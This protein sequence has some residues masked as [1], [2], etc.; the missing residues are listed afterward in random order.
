MNDN[1]N[2]GRRDRR[3]HG[4]KM[5]SLGLVVGIVL[6]VAA[7]VP[8]VHAW[9]DSE[10]KKLDRD[11][12]T[13]DG[14]LEIAKGQM[15]IVNG[16]AESFRKMAESEAAALTE[17]TNKLNAQTATLNE[18]HSRFTVLYD[19]SGSPA[20]GVPLFHGIVTLSL[21][22]L[23]AQVKPRWLIPAKVKPLVVGSSEWIA[24]GYIDPQ[25]RVLEGPFTPLPPQM[26]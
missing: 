24:Y 15:G 19:T 21:T 6:A 26:E 8:I 12:M 17:C 1:A 13:A 7:I 18:D 25:T 22:G 3:K 2:E 11:A 9:V 10:V 4:W 16:S 23:P 14:Q 20:P 5:F